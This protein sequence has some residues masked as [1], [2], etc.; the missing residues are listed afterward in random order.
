MKVRVDP[1]VCVGTGSCVSICPEVFQIGDEGI[2]V[3]QVEVVPKELEETC[4]EAVA[5]CPVDAIAIV[6]E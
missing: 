4:R 6:K 2:S 5:S 1:D 3:V